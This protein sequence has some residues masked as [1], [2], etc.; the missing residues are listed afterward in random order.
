MKRKILILALLGDPTIPAGIPFSGG[1]NQTLRELITA[2]AAF[3][4]PI[5]IITDT[6][7]YR[8]DAYKRIS[9]NIELFRV[10]VTE[11]ERTNQENLSSA[12][13]RILQSIYE[14]LGEDIDNI[15][16]IHSFYWFSGHLA[17]RINDQ[18]GVPYIHTPISLSYD[19]ISIGCQP[20]CFFQVKCEPDFLQAA[21]W[22]LAITEQEAQTL[23]QNYHVERSKIIITGRSVDSVFH[24]PARDYSGQPRGAVMAKQ[25]LSAATDAPWWTSGAF[26][27]L[28]RMVPI[29]GVNEIISAWSQLYQRHGD[30]T[31]PLWLV[32]GSPTQ[33]S[34]LRINLLKQIKDLPLY[35]TNQ[36][37]VW[38]GYL[39]QASISA[40]LLKTLALVTHSRFEA[41]G[42]VILETMCQGRPVIAT[43]YGFAAD[44]IRDWGNGFL[45]PYGDCGLLA[46]RMEHFIYQPYLAAAMGRAARAAFQKIEHDWNYVGT[47]TKLYN[48]YLASSASTVPSG[49]RDIDRTLQFN[50]N[51][52]ELIDVFPYH[53]IQFTEAEWKM[54]LE[55]QMKLPI[56]RFDKV[57]APG[58]C[59]HHFTIEADGAEFKMKQFFNRMNR[60]SIWDHRGTKKVFGCSEQFQ[61]AIQSVCFP[62]VIPTAFA[63][64]AD[65]Y[66]VLP[67]LNPIQPNCR[68]LY[69][70]LDKFCQE[71]ASDKPYNP[72]M[73]INGGETLDSAF[74]ALVQSTQELYACEAQKLLPYRPLIHALLADSS[75]D[76]RFGI[77]YG[78]PL[79]GHIFSFRGAPGLLPTCNWYW[80]ELG[81][82]YVN[83]SIMSG[84]SPEFFYK[85]QKSV[86]MLLWYLFVSWRNLLKSEWFKHSSPQLWAQ[87]A[88]STIE[89]L[90]KL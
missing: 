75:G 1:F 58:Q 41:G 18:R 43:P 7:A 10:P 39:D 21:D 44:Y 71:K 55:S 46:H 5:C 6:S 28:G 3:E 57:N 34:N 25:E 49:G 65:V 14:T 62:S 54:R 40:L 16:L 17:K 53:D 76:V 81:V 38:W 82:D 50:G 24:S 13:E 60:D 42:R 61:A 51:L 26:T 15:A 79:A 11:I 69:G 66:Y 48:T 12:Q 56:T 29:K 30:Q 63:C 45:V 9:K 36:K 87:A 83:A 23:Q 74:G 19:K 37:I 77:N 68:V 4:L 67:K 73:Q 35:E 78:K 2:L 20:N 72:M 85:Q 22:V 88:F 52:T 90:K 27:Y 33:I 80:G 89:L 32:G 70:I 31:P 47:H 8:S 59:A 86:R 84:E 64:E